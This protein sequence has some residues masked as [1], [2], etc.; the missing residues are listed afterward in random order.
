LGPWNATISLV[1][2]A[3]CFG[4]APWFAKNLVDAGIAPIS[5]AFYR[6]LTTAV[7][8][9]IFL[10]V[11]RRKYKETLW[12]MVSGV[13]IGIGWITY[14]GALRTAPVAT[15]GVIYMTYPLFTLVIASVWLRQPPTQRSLISGCLVL[16]AAAI[17]LAP[18]LSIL[19]ML[20]ALLLAFLAPIGFAFA[21]C[22]LTQKLFSLDPIQRSAGVSLGAVVGLAPFIATQN[23]NALLPSDIYGWWM[24]LG[25][26]VVTALIPNMLFATAGPVVGSSRTAA[27]S[28]F[29]LPVM[30]IVGLVGFNETIGVS[31]VVAGALII[32]AIL[33]SPV[34]TPARLRQSP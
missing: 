26:S 11:S 14:V 17:A 16:G 27:A 4:L 18:S 7:V 23:S 33:V 30:F 29:E 21:I 22:V 15:V 9:L 25:I 28:S 20:S 1:V 3:I 5:V 10:D 32:I 8:L 34:V 31:Q 2:A 12:S 24:I 6:F 13:A 19:P